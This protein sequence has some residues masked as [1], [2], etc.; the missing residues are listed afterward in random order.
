MIAIIN[1]GVCDDEGR[2]LYRI[3][4]NE[5]VVGR[6]AHMRSD[7][8]VQCLLSAADTMAAVECEKLDRIVAE[9]LTMKG[10]EA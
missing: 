7:G 5:A 10:P 9:C 1:S 4:I 3:Q 2:H 8:L 6:F